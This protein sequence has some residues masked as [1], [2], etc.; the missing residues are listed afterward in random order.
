M[1]T[2]GLSPASSAG[3]RSRS[4][5]ADSEDCS[6]EEVDGRVRRDCMHSSPTKE[7]DLSRYGRMSPT[8]PA[9]DG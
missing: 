3:E 5:R 7:P 1:S 2:S 6:E 9:T 4:A 8:Y